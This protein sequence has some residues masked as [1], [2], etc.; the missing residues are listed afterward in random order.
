M[1]ETEVK[2]YS[3]GKNKAS[4]YQIIV[5]LEYLDNFE[6]NKIFNFN[7]SMNWKYIYTYMLCVTKIRYLKNYK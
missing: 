3:I 7:F 2:Y 5:T 1:N 4:F 6:I